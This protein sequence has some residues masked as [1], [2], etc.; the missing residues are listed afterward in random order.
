MNSAIERLLTLRVRDVMRREVITVQSKDTMGQ[1]ATVLD[2]HQI[3]GLPVVDATG[4]CVGIL[5]SSDFVHK[6]MA[7]ATRSATRSASDAL[8]L[9]PIELNLVEDHMSPLVQTVDIETPIM[10]AARILCAEHIH[11]LVAV[12][13]SQM[14]VGILSSLDIVACM[15]AAIEE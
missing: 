6:E 11:R 8:C 7:S 2:T 10:N 15:V 9:E 5:S 4:A 12:D 14:P 13:E 1:A 3:T